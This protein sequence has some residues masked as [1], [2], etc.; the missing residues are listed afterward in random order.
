MT[1]AKKKCPYCGK[2]FNVFCD[3]VVDDGYDMDSKNSEITIE[4]L[5]GK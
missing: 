4:K 1:N 2:F 3:Q 5:G